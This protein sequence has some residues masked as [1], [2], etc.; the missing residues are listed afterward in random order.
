AQIA[1][2]RWEIGG[3]TW[4]EPDTNLPGGESLVRQ[5]LFGKRYMRDEFGVDT[6]ILWMPDV[7]GYSYALP[8][9]M[10]RSGLRYLMTTKL[11]WN[12][13]NRFPYD[14]FRWRGLDGSEVLTH[15]VTTPEE[16]TDRFAYVGALQPF[17]VKGLWDN[18]KQKDVND[19]L[20]FL[21]GWGDGGGGPTKEMLESG[22]VLRNL[23]GLPSVEFGKAEPYFERLERRLEGQDLPVWDGELYLEYHRGTYTSQAAVK[24]ANREAEM[25]YHQAEWLASL[26]DVCLQQTRYPAAE[27]RRGW[28]K[29]LL[30]QFHDIL[31][32][33]SIR[34]VY[35]DAQQDYAL[36]SSI[37]EQVRAA[38][39]ARLLAEIG[40]AQP[41]LVVFNSTSQRRSDLVE[42]DSPEGWEGQTIENRDGTA[43]PCQVVERNGEKKILLHAQS[44]PPLGY[45][46]YPQVA[47]GDGL[48]VEAAPLIIT[49]GYLQ[50]DYYRIELNSHGHIVSLYDRIN[51][52]QVLAPNT[53]ANVLQAFEDKPMA[54]DAWDI[55][56]YYRHKVREVDELVEAVV[57]EQGPLRGV[58][59]LTWKL[60]DST[61]T[62]RM[63]LYRHSP[64]IDFRTEIE[65]AETQTLLKAAFPVSIRATRATYDIQFGSIER[66]NHWNT[67]WDY[68]RFET[69]AHK[70]ADLSEGDYGVALLNDCKYGYDVKENVLRITL[71]KSAIEPDATADRGHHEFTYSL[72]P[73]RGGWR[74]GGVVQEAYNLNSP[75]HA[76]LIPA[77]PAAPLPPRLA[78]VQCDADN[79]IVETVKQAEDDCAWVV[80]VYEFKQAHREPV[81]LTF[82][83]EIKNA[84][85]CNLLEEDEQPVAYRGR[86]LEFAVAPFEIRTFKI[87]F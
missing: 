63:T 58:L 82:A 77:Q 45:A 56:I 73:H 50:N 30:N 83:R 38:A 65:W 54:F 32:G 35:E 24:R 64:R 4:I 76:A 29:I 46:T 16:H 68:A 3:A 20:L 6:H 84:A 19:E 12:Q 1:A 71:L 70:W 59:R 74:D 52:R 31:P 75:L 85:E 42:L 25:L 57:E 9:I 23:P 61:I 55:D 27:L 87:W 86:T 7:F 79:V 21:Y 33:S 80:R 51:A 5:V 81:H 15:F 26:A 67:S 18:Y 66:P 22:R 8:Q 69:F 72:L 11:S 43:S 34:Q 62:Q 49:P 53:R 37:G 60:N 39:Q 28:E 13:F 10:A 78:F 47:R 17:E 40:T 36:V 2:G 48:N 41:A 44:V 14:T